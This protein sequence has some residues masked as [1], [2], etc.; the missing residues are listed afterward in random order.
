MNH[1]FVFLCCIALIGC[2]S[3]TSSTNTYAETYSLD[4]ITVPSKE[5]LI[6]KV[7]AAVLSLFTQHPITTEIKIEGR[8]FEVEHLPDNSIA[9]VVGCFRMG[10]N[11]VEQIEILFVAGNLMYLRQ[12]IFQGENCQNASVLMNVEKNFYFENER[13]HQQVENAKGLFLWKGKQELKQ[14]AVQVW[15]AFS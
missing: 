11:S 15:R 13:V 12:D 4:E 8:S 9:R 7:N 6:D 1:K 3:P 10:P 14:L 2:S 5:E